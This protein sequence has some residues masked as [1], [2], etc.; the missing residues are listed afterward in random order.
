MGKS[1]KK[2]RKTKP[3]PNKAVKNLRSAA[4]SKNLEFLLAVPKV[5]TSLFLHNLEPN[6]LSLAGKPQ[7]E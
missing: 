7:P 2:S 6:R 4:E 5:N 3:V 1:G